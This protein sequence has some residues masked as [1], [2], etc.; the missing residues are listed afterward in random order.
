MSS[1]KDKA[2][3]AVP[4]SPTQTKIAF[5]VSAC[6]IAYLIYLLTA[7][8]SPQL[9]GWADPPHLSS[10]V[11][12][13]LALSTVLSRH[14]SSDSLL[15]WWT[16]VTSTLFIIG[17][18]CLQLLT[19]NRA[20]EFLDI[21]QGIAGA[22]IAAMVAVA[23]I[24][25][26]GRPAYVWLA[27]VVVISVLITSL[28]LLRTEEPESEVSCAPP[29]NAQ[30]NWDLVVINTFIPDQQDDILLSS[31]IGPLCFF[32]Q[33]STRAVIQ[34]PAEKTQTTTD[35]GSLIL[36][37][38]GVVSSELTGLRQ[39]LSRSR[40]LTF[41]IRF[42][43]N[44]LEVGRP[45]RLVA[46]VQS[47]DKPLSQVARLL[48]NGPNATAT[49]SFQPWQGSST[50]LAN[51]LRNQYQEVVLTYDGTVQT[52]YL[53]GIPVGTETTNIE[54]IDASGSELILNIGKR[55][56]RRWKPFLGEISAIVIGTKSVSAD[57]IA[58][59]FSQ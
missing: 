56:D 39:A 41:G 27:I 28:L 17:F 24:R 45:P 54:A 13:A 55:V 53:D 4:N 1:V 35:N 22:A 58:T 11:L 50:V 10:S 23:I 32:D 36:S 43:T 46:S 9:G 6:S 19:P 47:I 34:L 48:Q 2:S 20:F 49:F 8:V 52:T 51:R 14:I 12:L 40:E 44:D 21:A 57:K 16:I 3:P 33:N 59:V 15:G 25:V 37:G 26:I 31:S 7:Q 30:P 38:F 5:A 29:V 42:K 18:E